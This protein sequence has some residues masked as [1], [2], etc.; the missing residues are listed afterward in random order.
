MNRDA[1]VQLSVQNDS[2]NHCKIIVISIPTLLP[3]FPNLIRVPYSLGIYEIKTL[4]NK[5]IKID[6]TLKVDPGGTIPTWLVNL[7]ATIAPYSTFLKLR[8]IA[9]SN[10]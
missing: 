1:T 4:P 6:Y 5:H 2:L 7:T 8:Q 9:E 10:P 3:K